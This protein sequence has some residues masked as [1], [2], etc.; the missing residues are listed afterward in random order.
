MMNVNIKF[1]K[2]KYDDLKKGFLLFCMCQFRGNNFNIYLY[3]SFQV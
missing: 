3:I 2:Y 1:F